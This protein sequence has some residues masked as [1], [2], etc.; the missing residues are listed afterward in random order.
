MLKSRD[1]IVQKDRKRLEIHP[2]RGVGGN[3]WEIFVEKGHQAA[4][5]ATLGGAARAQSQ[6]II[7]EF[8]SG[9]NLGGRP[10]GSNVRLTM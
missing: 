8:R 1:P 4:M 9:K 10:C 2:F 3:V 7:F 5:I 6:V